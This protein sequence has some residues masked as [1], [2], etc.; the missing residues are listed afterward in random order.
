MQS[1]KW[2]IAKS[3]MWKLK[4]NTSQ[5]RIHFKTSGH[6]ESWATQQSQPYRINI[7]SR[8]C[9]K[10]Q[11]TW[12]R[13]QFKTTYREIELNS[14]QNQM[15]CTAV[16]VVTQ[17]TNDRQTRREYLWQQKQ[18]WWVA[19]KTNNKQNEPTTNDWNR[20]D[21][22]LKM[23]KLQNEVTPRHKALHITTRYGARYTNAKVEDKMNA[24]LGRIHSCQ[25]G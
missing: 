2:T 21:S 16:Q 24:Q 9:E 8:W 1:A 3:M 11:A 17:P 4:L 18:A 10:L 19:P 13:I 7:R 22:G 20:L 15:S 5:S 25:F 14:Q 6:E 23:S 12:S